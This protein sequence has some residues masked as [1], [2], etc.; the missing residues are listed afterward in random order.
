MDSISTNSKSGDFENVI[1]EDASK[2]NVS[3][4]GDQQYLKYMGYFLHVRF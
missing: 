3:L 1:A 2:N 4:M